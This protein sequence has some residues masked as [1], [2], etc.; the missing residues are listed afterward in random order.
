[1]HKMKRTKSCVSSIRKEKSE[2]R[3]HTNGWTIENELMNVSLV[4]LSGSVFILTKYVR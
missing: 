4:D 3:H 2:D 1:M